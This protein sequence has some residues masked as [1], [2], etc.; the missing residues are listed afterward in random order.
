[1]SSEVKI[2][3]RLS[4]L[5]TERLNFYRQ[6]GVEAVNMPTHYT[7]QSVARPL[8]PH[9]PPTQKGPRGPI[10]APWDEGE[11]VRIRDRIH[12]FNLVPATMG[13]RLSGN[14][15]MGKAGRDEDLE[16]V[17][18][19]IRVA[20][21]VGIG[22]LTHSFTALRASEGYASRQ[23]SGRGTADLRDFDYERIR[24]LP[25]LDDVGRHSLE[26]MWERLAYFLHVVVP[27][28]E[29]SG[30][31]LAAHPNDP[32]VPEYRGVAQP[33]NDFASFKRLI[34]I[35]DSPANSVFFDTGVSTEWGE[36]AVE[37]IRYF[38]SRGRIGTVHFRNVRVDV[39]RY[40]Y[41]E[42][43]IDEGECDM[44]SCMQTFKEVGYSG[45]VDPDHTPKISGDTV[46]TRLGWTYAVAYIRA[47]RSCVY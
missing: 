15:L 40:N 31:R 28:A 19:D 45:S 29:E 9:V 14:I 7:M 41:L 20:G 22:V 26:E 42:T 30:V 2:S 43:F 6:I 5:S 3:M 32:P 36:D 34:E 10:G 39:P 46:D 37:V 35:V 18:D 33:L 8:A 4:D 13:L 25:P 12:A 23:G 24:N 16:Q 1:M 11:L 17:R 47:L 38:G 27:V 21:R 44:R